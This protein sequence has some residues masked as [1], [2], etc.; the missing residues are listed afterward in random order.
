MTLVLVTG[1][2][3]FIGGHIAETLLSQGYGV[4]ILD[5][6]AS[7]TA[8]ADSVRADV[9]DR[10]SV[11]RA[12]EGA[13]FVFHQAAQVAILRS[14]QDPTETNEINVAGTLNVLDAARKANVRKVV[15][16]SSSSVYGNVPEEELPIREDRVLSPLSPYAASKLAAEHYCRVYG[17]VYGLP[18]ICLRYLNVYGPRQSPDSPYAA[19]IPRFIDTIT[20]GGRPTV[21]GD[22]RQTRDFVFVKDVVQANLLAM[23]SDVRNGVFNVGTGVPVTLNELIGKI[24]GLAGRVVA[25]LHS[26]ARPG[27]IRHSVSDITR[28]RDALG[29]RPRYGLNRGLKETLEWFAGRAGARPV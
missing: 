16:A 13:E 7:A 19:A 15:F 4:R 17:E 25:P 23:E 20:K 9:R 1:G 28:I 10:E 18:T 6:E 3:G 12:M 5:R 11:E 26:P 8:G 24:G 29:Y 21:Y 14:I 27:D 22:G 2:A